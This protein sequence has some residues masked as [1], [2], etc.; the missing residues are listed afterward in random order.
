MIDSFVLHLPKVMGDILSHLAI[1][2]GR[3]PE[4]QLLHWV[5]IGLVIDGNRSNPHVE[6]MREQVTDLLENASFPLNDEDVLQQAKD[7]RGTL[8]ELLL[9]KGAVYQT[10][11]DHPELSE[12]V[13][14]D[15]ST[16][17]GRFVDGAFIP[18]EEI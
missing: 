1:Q 16:T 8:V 11:K 10:C 9:P 7:A 17:V 14:P 18:A 12:Q 4:R 6:R 3:T 15:G 13:M 5:R 2:R